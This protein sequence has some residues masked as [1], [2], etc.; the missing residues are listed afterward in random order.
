MVMDLFMFI[1]F[2][3]IVSLTF[4]GINVHYP[5]IKKLKYYVALFLFVLGCIGWIAVLLGYGWLMTAVVSSALLL[6]AVIAFFI[7]FVLDFYD[8]KKNQASSRFG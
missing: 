2:T 8:R 3:F 1:A 6:L 5:R 7:A 4:Y